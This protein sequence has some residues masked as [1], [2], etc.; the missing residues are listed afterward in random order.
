MPGVNVRVHVIE[1]RELKGVDTGGTS[2][3]I[4]VVTVMGKK[5]E[6]EQYN[7]CTS[8]VFDKLMFFEFDNLS[9]EEIQRG[10]ILLEMFD[11]NLI[12][13]NEL[14]GKYEFGVGKT[15]TKPG[16]EEYKKWVA[17]FS[18]ERGLEP[19]GFLKVSI[20][21][22][23]SGQAHS[24][25]MD[26]DDDDDDEM[27]LMPPDL[28]MKTY[29]LN[30]TV[31]RAKD[32]PKVD[33]WGT[34]DGYIKVLFGGIVQRT[35]TVENSLNPEWRVELRMPVAVPTMSDSI[36]IS[37]YDQDFGAADDFIGSSFYSY[38][39][40]NSSGLIGP[41]WSHLFGWPD[42]ASAEEIAK[43][44]ARGEQPTEYKG[45]VLLS[46]M[47][48]PDE[49]ARVGQKSAFNCA[50]PE[51]CKYT[52]RLDVFQVSEVPEAL[53]N[54]RVYVTVGQGL[55]T[56]TN[57]RSTRP[58][59]LDGVSSMEWL[60]N[61]S[62]QIKFQTTWPKLKKSNPYC[63]AQVPDIFVNLMCGGKRIG[64]TRFKYNLSTTKQLGQ[65]QIKWYTLKPDKFDNLVPDGTIPGFLQYRLQFG[66]KDKLPRAPNFP[67]TSSQEYLLRAH[68]FQ[69]K[70]LPS[71]DDN[72]MSD[73]FLEIRMGSQ[74]KN[75][76][77]ILETLYPRW[78]E[79]TEFQVRLPTNH[80]MR[81]D[82]SVLVW[83]QDMF[84]ADYLGRFIVPSKTI[85]PKYKDEPQWREVMVGDEEDNNKEGF[86]LCSF[87]LMKQSEVARVRD[88][89]DYGPEAPNGIEPERFP[90]KFEVLV[91][92]V[93]NLEP[94]NLLD[95][96]NPCV[97]LDAGDKA[98]IVRTETGSGPNAS[99]MQMKTLQ[100]LLPHKA[101]FAPNINV[102]V[103]D[104]RLLGEVV[105]GTSSIP[106]APYMNWSDSALEIEAPE[107]KD[108]GVF[109][110]Q[111]EEGGE[112]EEDEEQTQDYLP[113]T[114][115]EANEM[116]DQEFREFV[117]E[118][119]VKAK[120]G[121]GQRTMKAVESQE[122][123]MNQCEEEEMDRG[124]KKEKPRELIMTQWEVSPAGFDNDNPAPFDEYKIKRG[125]KKGGGLLSGMLGVCCAVQSVSRRV[126]GCPSQ[127]RL[128]AL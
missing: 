107:I 70:E 79:T 50:M 106:V 71:A 58:I 98:S 128:L 20:S 102:R 121:A 10:T 86:I 31:F 103:F 48:E 55:S 53:T 42:T 87:Q 47:T 3:P 27:V 105:V 95:C 68:I 92:G 111:D 125:Q 54:A 72:G 63:E 41:H 67:A 114:M 97:E 39:E 83:D 38:R 12:A 2:D 56:S 112:H 11:Y 46:M 89:G 96:N 25:H 28:D 91:V 88:K 101:L 77:V 32:L 94:Y 44:K 117:F 51:E 115:E 64:Y 35:E 22:V 8:V 81:P 57:Y 124:K 104:D 78:Y 80:E 49:N 33:T 16:H 5:Q 45:S 76:S 108:A 69:G 110:G 9:M 17:L 26:D 21:V 62:A 122:L 119:K 75:T 4:G 120:K 99:F 65:G 100:L 36:E 1:A 93:R 52:L 116:E 40:I 126:Q 24:D 18:P 118:K 15:N 61:R 30:T 127:R 84:S 85:Q 14:I 6:T 90:C 73:P 60:D 34:C 37:L 59:K 66:E 29:T 43:V 13:R 74:K 7:K 123:A 109:E 23:K 113:F 82:I 19:Q